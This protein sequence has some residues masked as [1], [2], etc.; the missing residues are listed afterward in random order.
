MSSFHLVS[1]NTLNLIILFWLLVVV[2]FTTRPIMLLSKMGTPADVLLFASACVFSAS[3][4]SGKNEGQVHHHHDIWWGR[5][6]SW[7]LFVKVHILFLWPHI[8]KEL[9]I[10][11]RFAF[12]FTWKFVHMWKLCTVKVLVKPDIHRRIII[13][14]ILSHVDRM[15]MILVYHPLKIM[16][17]QYPDVNFR[18]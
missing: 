15:I 7:G 10:P 17:S 3:W 5:S 6:S 9:E 4:R 1:L 16:Q 13:F 14:Y 2:M 12:Y 18:W 8:L 11:C